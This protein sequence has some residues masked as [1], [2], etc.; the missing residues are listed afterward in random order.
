LINDH[1][2]EGPLES[3][4]SRG[5]GVT[6][7]SLLTGTILAIC[8]STGAP[9]GNMVLRGS[10][11]ALDFSTAGAIFLFF[12]LVLLVHTGLGLIH[13]RLA[14]RPE[15]LVV[16]YIMSI[17]SCSIP[18][19]GLT[20]YLLPIMSGAHYYATTENEW[21]LL[22]HPYIKSWMVPQEFTAVKY[23][24][25]GSPRGVGITWL[26][27]VTPLLT[28]I[29]MILAIYFSMA[30]IMVMLRKQWIVRERLAFP[31]VQVPLAMIEDDNS[32]RAIKPFFRNWLM[33]AGFSLPL[34][35]GSMKALHNYYNFVPTVVTQMSIPLFRNTA[36]LQIALSFPMLG[37][38]YLVNT[39][40]ALSIW[41]FSLLARA[42]EGIF[43]VL[44]ISSPEILY[45]APPEPIVAHQ[46]MGA[47]LVMVLFGLWTARSH[48]GD[49]F[50]KAFRGDPEVDDSDEMMSYRVAVFGFLFANVFISLWLW[51][52][53]MT[54]WVVPIY[55]GSMYMVFL[56]ITRLVAEG[57][58][59]AARAP[60]IPSDFVSSGLGNSVLD[61][62]TL[63]VL[64]F[65]YVW[66]ADVRTFV[67]ASMANGL[68]LAEDQLHRNKRPLFWAIGISVV[69]SIVASVW[70]IMHMS[71]AYGGINLNGWF[72]GPTGGPA[73]PWN[74]VTGELN[75]PD[76]P[77]WIGWIS[78]GVGAS[79]MA[80]LMLARHNFLW[81]P[82]HPLG[83]AVSS[84][85]LSNYLTLSVF[86]AWLIK[87][88]ILKY[89][90]PTLFHRARPFFLGLIVGQF[91]VA[92]I[93][94]V[95]DYFT[96]MTDNNIYWI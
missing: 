74:Y 33:W 32:G 77:D 15:E 36:S 47:F 24:Y 48:L 1:P 69:V 28:W 57:G 6:F 86:L 20:E 76:G 72:F 30:C 40:I 52:A 88:I 31:L 89:G 80:L 65:T 95:I 60:L 41:F 34:I 53:G 68:K 50:R 23:F 75:N 55:L 42:Q 14:F 7:R 59:A 18:T 29:P 22:I 27:W 11:M 85:S 21:G 93:W 51:T 84:I 66:A 12:I 38:M 71:Y 96:G 87:S 43:G 90:G 58:I 64:G 3:R 37:F 54:L 92:G 70:A 82:V 83:F 91:F 17:V 39:D 26:P 81:W 9:Y 61:S 67:M 79:V 94:L 25:E 46:G 5:S 8:I 45:Y 63:V 44:G 62:S 13:P 16:I 56:A 73:Y 19:M 35:V 49:V 2:A 4:R 10:Y 78:T